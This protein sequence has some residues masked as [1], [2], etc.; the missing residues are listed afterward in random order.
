MRNAGCPQCGSLPRHRLI[1]Y[2]ISYFGLDYGHSSLLHVGPNNIEVAL[3]LRRYLPHP[4]YRLD[5]TPRPFIN[6]PG[7]LSN[8]PLADCSVQQALIW[9][10]L[11]HVPN[12]RSAIREFYRVLA[13]GGKLL[14]SVPLGSD[15]TFEDPATPPEKYREVYGDADHVRRCGP[16][17]FTRFCEA[18]FAVEHLNVKQLNLPDKKFFGLSDDH[19]AW[20]CTK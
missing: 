19:V 14:V 11:E 12:D 7:N 1:P 16:D 8:L 20:C 2:A 17:Y 15:V 5:L 6:L 3:I 10:V 13:N 9:H 4:Y 18:G